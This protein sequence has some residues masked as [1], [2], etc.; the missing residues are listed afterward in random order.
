MF[1][2]NNR[3]VLRRVRID[4]VLYTFSLAKR[5]DKWGVEWILSEPDAE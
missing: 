3:T 1:Y 4:D 2:L 5:G